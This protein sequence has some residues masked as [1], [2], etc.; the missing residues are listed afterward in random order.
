ME[1]IG[2]VQTIEKD[3]YIGF[4]SPGDKKCNAV[5]KFSFILKRTRQ[6]FRSNIGFARYK[7]KRYHYF[8]RK[9]IDECINLFIKDDKPIVSNIVIIGNDSIKR[10]LFNNEKFQKYFGKIII[11]T[12]NIN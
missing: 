11:N 6:D 3:T 10:E 5:N 12:L 2:F 7:V 9:I 8:A 1:K 4:I